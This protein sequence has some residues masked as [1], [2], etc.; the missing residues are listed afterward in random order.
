MRQAE[1]RRLREEFGLSQ[2]H[3]CE[4]LDIPR[5]TYRYVSRKDDS[6]LREKLVA[7][8]HEQPRYGYRRLQVLLLR[9]YDLWVNH[10]RVHRVYRAAGLQVRRIRRRRLTRSMTP[11]PALT[12]PNQEWALDFA[13]DATDSGQRFRTLSVI[14][15]YTRRC[16]A[17]ETDTSFPSRRVTRVL[18]AVIARYGKPSAVRSDNG[19][20]LTSRHYLAWFVEQK[21][22]AIHIQPGR[23]MQNGRVES[24]HGR[25]RDECLNVNCFLNLWDARRKIAAWC[26]HYNTRR[27][28]S[29]LGYRTPEEFARTLAPSPSAALHGASGPPPQGQALR[30]PAAALTQRP[31]CAVDLI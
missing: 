1:V 29:R 14:D 26:I 6:A 2:R 23:P 30:A 3:A 18:E 8:A 13:H 25:L 22:A 4:L 31:T 17:L 19:P 12:G 20:E 5:S 7:L 10:K 16:L 21:I 15:A 27:P 9:T 28:H 24:F 11:R